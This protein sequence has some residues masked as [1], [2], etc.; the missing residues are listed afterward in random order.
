VKYYKSKQHDYV[1]QIKTVIEKIQ[2]KYNGDIDLYNG[3]IHDL[4]T[5]HINDKILQSINEYLYTIS[6]LYLNNMVQDYLI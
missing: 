5:Y 2:S 3:L 1:F 6:K 4:N